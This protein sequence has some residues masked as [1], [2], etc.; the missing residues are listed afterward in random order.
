MALTSE[1]SS[2][3]PT[4]VSL[5]GLSRMLRRSRVALSG[6]GDRSEQVEKPGSR[7]RIV[8]FAFFSCAARRKLD[9]EKRASR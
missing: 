1:A 7:E 2:D 3:C 9:P 5:R 4:K 6:N 8:D